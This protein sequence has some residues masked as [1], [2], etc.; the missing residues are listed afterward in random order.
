MDTPERGL[1]CGI[2]MNKIHTTRTEQYGL[3]YR[4][5][6]DRYQN[7]TFIQLY[8]EQT[9]LLSPSHLDLG[10]ICQLS[11]SGSGMSGF[12]ACVL[13]CVLTP[14]FI[15]AGL[16]SLHPHP[17][18]IGGLRNRRSRFTHEGPPS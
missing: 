3:Y 10:Q 5:R 17:S 1:D 15:R 4:K 13:N 7:T 11:V 12:K 18:D 2:M 14:N 9:R 16:L 8:T 6:P